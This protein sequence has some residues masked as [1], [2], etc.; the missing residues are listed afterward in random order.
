[1]TE[2]DRIYHGRTTSRNGQAS[3]C[4]Y[5]CA[6]WMAEVD[7]P[8]QWWHLSESSN[9]GW[10]SLILV[11]WWRRWDRCHRHEAVIW[12]SV[13]RKNLLLPYDLDLGRSFRY[14]AEAVWLFLASLHSP[15][16]A[17]GFSNGSVYIFANPRPLDLNFR[18]GL[19][20][21]IV[22][23][24]YYSKKMHTFCVTSKLL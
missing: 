2:E 17:S 9:D 20:E 21:Q 15:Q 14:P 22:Q 6:S 1:M 19:F 3:R 4:H 10:A 12:K 7:E 5:C 8:S 24:F 16:P 13:G 23:V 11:S 18:G